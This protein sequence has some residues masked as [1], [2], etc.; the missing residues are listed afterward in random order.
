MNKKKTI[1]GVVG[2]AL[3]L[4][5]I[6]VVSAQVLPEI[7]IGN[8]E[9]WSA[10]TEQNEFVLAFTGDYRWKVMAICL[11]PEL[12]AP[13]V[14]SLC[15]F[16]GEIFTCPGAQNLSYVGVVE[17]PPTPTPPPTATP[18]PTDTVTPSFTPTVTATVSATPT[19]TPTS[20]STF[21]PTQTIQSPT[22]AGPTRTPVLPGAPASPELLATISAAN[23]AFEAPQGNLVSRFMDWIQGILQQILSIFRGNGS[24]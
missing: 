23:Q 17:Q 12:P 10:N 24:H 1:I 15:Y 6:Q 9:V 5:V 13:G 18:T 2:L 4:A 20:T 22:S 3:F 14:G 7:P 21:L 8:Y 16:D 19:L 11:Q